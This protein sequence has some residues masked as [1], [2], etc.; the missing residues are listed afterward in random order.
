[1]AVLIALLLS[2]APV[3]DDISKWIGRL[4]SESIEE[5]DE[6]TR[7]LQTQG[8]EA[9]PRLEKARDAAA[10][11]ATKTRID[12]IIAAIRKS[13]ELAK[14]FGPTKR[15][16][17]AARGK[18]IKEVLGEL[19]TPGIKRIDPGKLDVESRIDFQVRN[20]TW[21][22][23]L[24]RLARALKS[25][26]EIS[27]ESGDY[28]IALKPG[29]EAEGPVLYFEQ[30]RISVAEAKRVDFR[31]PAGKFEHALVAIEVR[32]QADLISSRCP[33]ADVV[34]IDS[35]V[36]AK[37]AD[38]LIDPFGL[39]LRSY[40]NPL[41]LSYQA[42][43]WVRHDAPQPL[44][45]SGATDMPFV[46]ET[47]EI[48]LDLEGDRSRIEVGKARLTVETFEQTGAGARL[49]LRAEAKDDKGEEEREEKVP[50]IMERLDDSS[51]VVLVDG[52]GRRH[53]GSRVSSRGGKDRC[54]WEITFS[55]GIEKPK[56]VVFRWVSE[57]H[58]VQ[59][60]F[61]LE[62]VRLPDRSK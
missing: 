45:V 55:T 51:E 40:D 14:V 5:R 16:T 18:L 10:D 23:A 38:A 22:E 15:V 36:D 35:V 39:P 26:Y 4:E 49:T 25:R 41:L 20:V 62:G 44:T 60:P 31:T 28:S 3:Q 42:N 9:I 47:K 8:V 2:L 6:A 54:A 12:A 46:S 59:I 33:V 17:I 32:H 53:A 29:V 27:W 37:G 56:R 24:D 7:R 21:W 57:I 50:W 1:V 52:A 58:R 11:A 61:R 30:F 48:E 13:A 19:R 34:R 43:A